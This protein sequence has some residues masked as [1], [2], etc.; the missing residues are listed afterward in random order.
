[1]NESRLDPLK[2]KSVQ[3]GFLLTDKSR[4][5]NIVVTKSENKYA[6]LSPTGI[7][8]EVRTSHRWGNMW[9]IF[10]IFYYCVSLS[11]A[12]GAKKTTE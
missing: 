7:F 2:L 11:P 6:R 8:R 10:Y 4:R 12:S 1:M 3:C 9:I 5:L